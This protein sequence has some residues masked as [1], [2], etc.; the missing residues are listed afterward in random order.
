MPT[1]RR[2]VHTTLL[3]FLVCPLT[4]SASLIL[5]D[6]AGSYPDLSAGLHGSVDYTFDPAAS[7]GL[8]D[9]ES[10]P[11][12]FSL[13]DDPS[14]KFP[15]SA[16][17]NGDLSESLQ[18]TLNSQGD[19]VTTSAGEPLN[20]SY[21]VYGSVTVNG[22]TYDGLL[23]SG[24][25]VAFGSQDL[26][27]IG[28]NGTD[29]FDFDIKITGGLLA[30]FFSASDY[31]RMQPLVDSTFAG[32]FDQS[33]TGGVSHG[34]LNNSYAVPEPATWIVLATGTTALAWGR[35]RSGRKS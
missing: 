32:Q 33:F 22:Q 15:V 34:Y 19:I 17:S 16:D 14:Q 23:I 10:A 21:N 20:G 30:S 6:P 27:S 18:L 28:I 24:T 5:P 11:Y 2:L 12:M 7:T 35:A 13:G 8:L 4:A 29:I 9:I 1:I 26:G 3:L 25:P 31:L